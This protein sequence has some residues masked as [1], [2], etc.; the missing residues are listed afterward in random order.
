MALAVTQ[1]SSILIKLKERASSLLTTSRSR[2]KAFSKDT[3]VVEPDTEDI[4]NSLDKATW[5]TRGRVNFGIR[6]G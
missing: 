2:S 5:W 1:T 4:P 3:G 6:R